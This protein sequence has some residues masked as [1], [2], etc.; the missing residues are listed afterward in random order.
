MF[1][2]SLLLLGLLLVWLALL[3]TALKL[4]T[5][6]AQTLRPRMVT[7]LGAVLVG[8]GYFFQPWIELDFIS[9]FNPTPEFIHQLFPREI[10]TMLVERFG[11]SWLHRAL[12]LFNI[13][14][15]LNGWQI[16]LLPTYD[17][18]TRGW[19]FLPL[20]CLLLA[21]LTVLIGLTV[22][23]NFLARGAGM[24]LI[25]VSVLDALGLLLSLPAIDALGIHNNFQIGLLAT[26]LGVH[27]GN[28]PW[29]C[30]FGLLVLSVGGAVEIIEQ[31]SS[32][33]IRVP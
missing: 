11:V 27:L 33:T 31:R 9:Y 28:G 13:F 26:L 18:L 6:I 21:L 2:L 29:I 1:D 24:A 17:W 30:V 15:S 19:A 32:S 8:G 10:A 23:G 20:F 22:P 4:K 5:P 3:G 16:Q 14:T 25:F 7:L 12:Q